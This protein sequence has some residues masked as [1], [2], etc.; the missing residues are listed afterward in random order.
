MVCKK[1]INKKTEFKSKYKT[2]KFVEG[3]VLYSKR[4]GKL[5]ILYLFKKN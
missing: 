5:F 2:G 3:G 4:G 1:C